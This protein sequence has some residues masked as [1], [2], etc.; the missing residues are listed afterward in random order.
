MPF[1]APQSLTANQ[2]YAVAAYVLY[3]NK[4]VPED[5]VLDAKTLAKVQ[6]P[7]RNGFTSP[8]PRPDIKSEPCM[9]DCQ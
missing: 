4:I 7:N 3:L 1:S 5:T 6:M 2:V 8:D 9:R